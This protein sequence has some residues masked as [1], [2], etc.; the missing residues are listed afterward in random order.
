MSTRAT[1]RQ[2]AHILTLIGQK[3]DD[4]DELTA[5]IE[6]GLLSD[7]LEASNVRSIDR[8][9]FRKFLGL[10]SLVPKVIILPVNYDTTLEQM[11]AV[12]NY[13]CRNDD[14]NTKNFP[15]IGEGVHWFEF[16]LI[17][18]PNKTW[19]S[20]DDALNL[21]KKDSD[22]KNPWMPGRIEH[23]L[24]LGAAFPD[25]QRKNSIVALGSVAKIHGDHSAPCLGHDDFRR[26]LYLDW[27]STSWLFNHRF[28][29]VRKASPPTTA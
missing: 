12:D 7:L 24:T 11:I 3:A 29:R 1:L 14:L 18:D 5:L 22:P 10:G 15:I 16:D 13:E 25:L 28:L 23:L 8:N 20:S 21:L 27:L 4:K 6:T 26:T 17:I 2:G 9:S 19:I